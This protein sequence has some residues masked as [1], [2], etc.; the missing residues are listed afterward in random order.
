MVDRGEQTHQ[1]LKELSVQFVSYLSEEG[2]RGRKLDVSR[3]SRQHTKLFS[4]LVGGVSVAGGAWAAV[5]VW[6]GSLGLAGNLALSLGLVATPIWVPFAGG[7]AGLSAA[8][9]ALYGLLSVSRSRG[10]RRQL[11]SVIGFSKILLKEEEFAPHDERV[12]RKFLRAKKVKEGDI[13]KLLQTTPEAAKKIA[14]GHLSEAQRQEIARY[15]FPLVYTGDG[16]ISSAG[17][18]RFA[19][20]CDELELEAGTSSVLSKDYR[21]RL[22]AQWSYLRTLIERLNHFVH[23]LMFDSREMELLRQQL[24]LL[25]SFDPRRSA[26]GKRSKTLQRLGHRARQ[27]TDDIR[28]DS[29]DEAA[30]M[31]AYAMAHTA[32]R[33]GSHRKQLARVFDLLVRQQLSLSPD[34]AHKLLE[35]RRKIDRMYATTLATLAPTQTPP[36]PRANA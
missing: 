35:T 18:R 30:L 31:S 36:A 3:F 27:P 25:M 29:V 4:G 21:T 17:R 13:E 8:G 7:V 11:Q 34:F 2:M 28:D 10:R 26:A 22:D 5:S 19:R 33:D 9:G 20:V 23:E 16:V 24:E 12:M 15:I 1:V 32:V 14:C 6:T